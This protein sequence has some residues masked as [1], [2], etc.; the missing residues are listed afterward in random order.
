MS[1][2]PCIPGTL[3]PVAPG[4]FASS[5]YGS[6][7]TLTWTSPD[8][9]AVASYSLNAT[10]PGLPVVPVPVVIPGYT[11]TY[12][13]GGLVPGA[14]YLLTLQ[15]V[16]CAGIGATATIPGRPLLIAPGPPIGV[17]A[18]A[19][20]NSVVVRLVACIVG[21]AVLGTQLR[22]TC[23]FLNL[24]LLHSHGK[25]LSLMVLVLVS[26]IQCGG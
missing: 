23:S 20:V 7:L 19:L 21:G 8:A 18:A 26:T 14:N 3:P 11:S 12:V 22:P 5:G 9:V 24:A 6:A 10:G 16:S 25:C 13:L 4:Y 15:A 2:Y 17:D 1:R